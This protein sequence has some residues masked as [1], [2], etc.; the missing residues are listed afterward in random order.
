VIGLAVALFPVG[1][2]WIVARVQAVTVAVDEP[3]LKIRQQGHDWFVALDEATGLPILGRMLPTRTTWACCWVLVTLTRDGHVPRAI[4]TDGLA[5]SV[6]ALHAVF[7]TAKQLLCVFQPHQGVGRWL[8]THVAALSDKTRLL[9]RRRRKRVVQTRDPRTVRRRLARLAPLN[10]QHHWG[11]GDWL[12]QTR[13]RLGR[14][15]PAVRQNPSPRTTNAIERF[16][17]AF[18]RVYAPRGGFHSVL[19]AKRELMRCVVVYVFTKQANTSSAPSERILPQASLT[20]L[21]N[22]LNDPFRYGLANR[23]QADNR[24]LGNLAT[25]HVPLERKNQ[26]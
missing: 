24:G 8:R 17:R 21:Y 3:W 10:A 11:L 26:C 6:G 25:Q 2:S 19:S 15:L 16:F 12:R 14:L 23:C 20:P 1:Q 5:G 18:Q 9:L 22:V 4:I 13:D 7:P